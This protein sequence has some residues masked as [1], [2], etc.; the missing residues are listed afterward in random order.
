MTIEPWVFAALVIVSLGH[1]TMLWYAS[2]YANARSR[3]RGS[4]QNAAASDGGDTGFALDRDP[5]RDSRPVRDADPGV[6][7]CPDCGAENEQ[8]YRYCA[9]CVAELPG[10]DGRTETGRGRVPGLV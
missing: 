2:R 8:G 4:E 10:A 9:R 1:L 5:D 3:E 6:V 7:T